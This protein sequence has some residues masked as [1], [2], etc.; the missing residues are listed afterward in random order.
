YLRNGFVP[1]LQGRPH[2]KPGDS[3]FEY[4]ASA[5]LEYGLADGAL[6]EMAARLGHR[7]DARR[8]AA[9]ALGYRRLFDRSTGFFRPRDTSGAFTGDPDP[10]RSPGFHEGSAW[11]YQWLVPQDLPGLTAL[12]GGR[13]AAERRLD[14]FFA[15]DR[16]L[17]DPAGTAR[18]SWVNG[19]YSYYN[20]DKY[21]P[22]NEPDLTAPYT[23]LSTG[24]PWK[25]T[26]VVHA[27]LTLFTDAPDGVT[28]ND[29][30]GTMS[31]WMVLSSIGVFPVFP[32]TDTWGLST[33]VFR[34]VD[35]KL[36]PRYYPRGRLRIRT[37]GGGAGH[38]IRSVAL[39]GRDRSRTWLSTGDLRRAS[40]LRFTVG[41]QPSQW[42]TRPGDAPPSER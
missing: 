27:A 23:Y 2:T 4:G 41:A 20:A 21:N 42:G 8:Y 6:A 10:A 35:L 40:E 22:Q 39:D 7:A 24:S 37:V 32:G 38:Y 13:R 28:G 1:F 15:Y 9:R 3:D 34:R 14:S 11:Q 30:L 29:D 26:D 16:L 17:A 36:D 33:P 18:R 31:S 12:L 25:T 5:T 19:P